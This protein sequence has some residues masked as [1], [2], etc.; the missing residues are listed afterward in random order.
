MSGIEFEGDHRSSPTITA[1]V[2]AASNPMPILDIARTLG[3]PYRLSGA[4]ATFVDSVAALG[5]GGKSSL[6]YS[7]LPNSKTQQL[8]L[9]SQCGALVWDRT[10]IAPRNRTVVRV[11]DPRGWFIDALSLLMQLD[12]DTKAPSESTEVPLSAV[13]GTG[14]VIE[15]GAIIGEGCV[16]GPNAYLSSAVILGND[17]QIGAGAVIGSSGLS[18]HE[19][20]DGSI[21]P[22]PHLGAVWI[23]DNSRIGANS[24]IVR[25]VLQDTVIGAS[26]ELGNQVNVG[27]NCRIGDGCFISSGV[28]LAGNCSLRQRV[29]LAAGAVVAPHTTIGNEALV[30]LGSVVVKDVPSGGKVF[31]VPA[32]PL[33]TMGT[34]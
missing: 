30:G 8:F 14:V 13:V 33:P 26:V 20:P 22:F 10:L 19:R 29:R 11:Q 18:P 27:H 28:V 34:F 9:E 32:Q 23:G 7:V 31:G 6:S 16:I 25:G 24:T 4:P 1:M 2:Y 15:A 3:A 17:V 12:A 5:S 21:V